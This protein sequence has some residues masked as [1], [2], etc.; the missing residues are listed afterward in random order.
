[1]S[2]EQKDLT[3]VLEDLKAEED[4]EESLEETESIDEEIPEEVEPESEPESV[5][6]V[7]PY[8]EIRDGMQTGDIIAFGGTSIFSLAV[9]A[10]TGKCKNDHHIA[11]V[12]MVLGTTAGSAKIVQLIEA[13]IT[14]VNIT[15][16]ANRVKYYEGEIWWYPIKRNL[17]V[18]T[19]PMLKWLLAQEGKPYDIPQAMLSAFDFIPQPEDLSKL[20]C[21]ELCV[22]GLERGGVIDDVI[23]SRITPVE[24]I[25]DYFD[26]Y[27]NPVLI[28]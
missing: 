18:K 12:A 25:D 13:N 26:I 21:S 19:K 23:S 2:E 28:S 1:M 8:T 17:Q 27:E 14:G 15:R 10:F 16:M 22:E 11:H 6:R 20:F 3:E 4:T 24:L 9:N 5:I 7:L